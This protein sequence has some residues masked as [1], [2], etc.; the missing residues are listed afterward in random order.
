MDRIRG[1]AESDANWI[2]KQ[3]YRALKKRLGRVPRSKTLSAHHA[4]T[5]LA[6]TWMDAVCASARTVPPVL[7]ELAQLKV[8]ALVG[9]PF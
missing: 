5:F 4:P 9:C 8:A 1:V 6:S 2:V 7:K 3:V